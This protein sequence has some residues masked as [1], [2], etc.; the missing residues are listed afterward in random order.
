MHTGKWVREA[1]VS[2]EPV[3]VMDRGRPAA[4]LLPLEDVKKAAF[5]ERTEVVGFAQLPEIGTD[6]GRLLEEDRR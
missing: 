1:A 5:S 3:I 6:S 2:H 4:R